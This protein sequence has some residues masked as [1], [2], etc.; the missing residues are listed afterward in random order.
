MVDWWRRVYA[1]H[2][3]LCATCRLWTGVVYSCHGSHKPV[4]VALARPPTS[5]PFTTS[6]SLPLG[7]GQASIHHPWPCQLSLQPATRWW[8]LRL[9]VPSQGRE[10]ASGYAAAVRGFSSP[11]GRPAG[12]A[13]M[14]SASGGEAATPA[15]NYSR[16][17]LAPAHSSYV[18]PG[19][20]AQER[21]RSPASPPKNARGGGHWS[22]PWY[23]QLHREP[24]ALGPSLTHAHI[25]GTRPP[26]AAPWQG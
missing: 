8:G 17:A 2:H 20:R 13:L 11:A 24:S 4:S 14:R 21:R 26:P 6:L 5:T 7:Q 22:I 3:R 16:W 23:C 12:R 1:A 10:R 15:I 9:N 18:L 25:P 19:A